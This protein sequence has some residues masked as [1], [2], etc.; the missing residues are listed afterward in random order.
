MNRSDWSQPRRQPIA[1]LVIVFLN[2]FWEIIK[3][4]WPFLIVILLGRESENS[5]SRYEIYALVFLG[6]TIISSILNFIFFRFYI[7]DEKLIIKKGWFKKETR[8]IPFHR[9]QTVNIEQGPLHQLL[10]IV[11]LSIDTAGSKTA[12]ATINALHK[13]MAEELRSKLGAAESRSTEADEEQE[14]V[15]PIIRLNGKDLLK[16]SISAN[17]LEAFFILLSFGIGLYENL[18]NIDDSI[19]SGMQDLVPRSSVFPILMLAV[20]ILVITIIVSSIRI[21]LQFWNFRVIRNASGFSIQSGLTNVKNRLVA[22][23]KIQYVSWNANWIRKLMDL[24]MLE[25][26]VAGADQTKTSQRVQ[27]PVT[28]RHYI[29]TL[30]QQFDQ[31]GRSIF[32]TWDSTFFRII[33]FTRLIK[34]YG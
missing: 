18:K 28:N 32:C 25:Y 2:T 9:I 4:I 12:E 10:N 11:K 23:E 20:F 14:P 29:G 6:F 24:W 16:L 22:L 13:S 7:E 34:S 1:G 30:F 17:H 21:F 19:F 5:S 3:R 31:L 26:H 27:L 33:V 15:I 8:V